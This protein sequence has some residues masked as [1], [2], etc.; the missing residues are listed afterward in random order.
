MKEIKLVTD[1]KTDQPK[2][3]SVPEVLKWMRKQTEQESIR[4]AALDPIS[5]PYFLRNQ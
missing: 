1:S 2:D 3:G 5:L 4:V